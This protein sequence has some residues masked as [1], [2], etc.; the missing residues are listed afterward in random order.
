MRLETWTSQNM[1]CLTSSTYFL[2]MN[3]TTDRCAFF[4]RVH[5]LA[6]LSTSYVPEGR[7]QVGIEYTYGQVNKHKKYSSWKANYTTLESDRPQLDRPVFSI[8]T[9]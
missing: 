8:I 7:A 4:W 6:D 5:T 1:C 2:T 3:H 9:Q